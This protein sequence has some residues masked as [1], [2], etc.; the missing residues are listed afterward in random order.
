MN[1]P[2]THR[3]ATT[4]ST[5][6]REQRPLPDMEVFGSALAQVEDVNWRNEAP[7]TEVRGTQ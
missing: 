4:Y 3:F 1:Y 5:Q 7:D 2:P 6:I